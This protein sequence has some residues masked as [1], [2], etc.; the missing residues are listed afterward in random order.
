MQTQKSKM[1]LYKYII[2]VPTS[3]DVKVETYIVTF[4]LCPYVT[5]K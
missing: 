1:K 2:K 4:D 5:L 3:V